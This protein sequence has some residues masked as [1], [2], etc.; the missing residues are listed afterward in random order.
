MGFFRSGVFGGI[1]R[2]FKGIA[3]SL[4]FS[5]R[6]TAAGDRRVTADGNPRVAPD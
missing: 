4:T 2:F 6:I 3:Q 5:F 1:S